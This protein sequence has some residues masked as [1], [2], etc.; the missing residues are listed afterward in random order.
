MLE[1][2]L[3]SP[4]MTA[5]LRTGKID[6]P[7]PGAARTTYND[8]VEVEILNGVK[9][10]GHGGGAPGVEAQLRIY[11]SLGYTVIVLTNQRAR[12]GRSTR[13]RASC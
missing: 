8:G 5:I 6:P 10:I 12:T 1:H 2:K 9:I 11:P 3:R 4:R 13:G 7:R